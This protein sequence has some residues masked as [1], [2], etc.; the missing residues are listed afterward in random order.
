MIRRNLF[1]SVQTITTIL[2]MAAAFL[3]APRVGAD[4]LP[5]EA[6][7]PLSMATKTVQAALEACKKDGYRVSVSVVDRAGVLRAMG[8][9][10]GVDHKSANFAGAE[11]DEPGNS[12]SRRRVADRDQWRRGGR[13]W[14]RWC[15]RHT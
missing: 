3:V 10:G 9:A 6:L 1:R 4:E 2:C 13:Y 11:G 15:T 7:L 14:C 5:K 8:R 12:D